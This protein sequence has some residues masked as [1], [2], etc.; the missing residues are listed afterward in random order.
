MVSSDLFE[1]RAPQVFPMFVVDEVAAEAIRHAW[2]E[3][4]DLAGVVELRRH[5]PLITDHARA[6]SCV[7]AI[8]GWQQHPAPEQ[9]PDR[10]QD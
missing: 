6:R 4:G 7:H 3:G 10:K 5:F 2:Q 1:T 8:M 9:E